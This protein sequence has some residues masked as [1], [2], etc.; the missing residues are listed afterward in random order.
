[1]GGLGVLL[2]I[3]V[4]LVALSGRRQAGTLEERLGSLESVLQVVDFIRQDLSQ[5]AYLESGSADSTTGGALA[6]YRFSMIEPPETK[7]ELYPDPFD[8]ER[9][10]SVRLQRVEYRFEPRSGRLLRNGRPVSAHRFQEVRFEVEEA[11]PGP[12]RF[13]AT[14]RSLSLTLQPRAAEGPSRSGGVDRRYE[15]TLALNQLALMARH[16]HWVPGAFH[17]SAVVEER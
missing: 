13:E 4:W 12:G 15:I 7:E 14:P 10:A 8:T 5:I 16:R 3:G 17:A 9:A 1:M 2:L 11:P 6:F